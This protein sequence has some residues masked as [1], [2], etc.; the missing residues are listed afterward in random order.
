MKFQIVLLLLLCGACFA[1]ETVLWRLGRKDG[2][3]QDFQI[4]YSP[5]EYGR[6]PYLR[7]NPDKKGF[8]F[9][10]RVRGSEPRP[11]MIDTITHRDNAAFMPEEEIVTT[12][13]LIWE[14]HEPGNRRFLLS[15][16]KERN[17]GERRNGI[18]IVL[19]DRRIQYVDFPASKQQYENF[20]N[21]VF[22][23][24]KGT[25][26]LELEVISHGK[27]A[28]ISFDCMEL[29]KTDAAVD[30]K[31]WLRAD[32]RDPD[33]VFAPG[34]AAELELH[35]FLPSGKA[36]TCTWK[37][38]DFFG[39]TVAKGEEQFRSDQLRL[40]LPSA[41]R[42]WF[43]V[44]CSTPSARVRTAY[45]VLE[46]VRL[47][48]DESSRFGL[49][50]LGD[51]YIDNFDAVAAEKIVRRAWKAGAKHL[52]YHYLKWN[53]R[54][55]DRNQPCSWKNADRRL[56]LMERY[57]LVP[58]IN[59]AGTPKWAS[60]DSSEAL[61]PPIGV[62][63]YTMFAPEEQAWRQF[64]TELVSRWKGRVRY[65]EIWNEPSYVSCFWLDGSPA[66]YGRT[67]KSAYEAAKAVDPECVVLSGGL[68]PAALDFMEEAI[69]SSGGCDFDVMGI[70]YPRESSYEQW[71]RM[72]SRYRGEIPLFNTEE[73][74]WYGGDPVKNAA[75]LVK[76]HVQEAVN[77]VV[78][79]Y[80]FLF[81]RPRHT[82]RTGAFYD[83]FDA[84]E[85]IYAAYR[86]MTHRMD[87]ITFLADLSE[88]TG[89]IFLFER[90]GA[91]VI[92]AWDDKGSEFPAVLAA[93]A[94]IYDLMDNPLP[95][96]SGPVRLTENPLFLAGGDLARLKQYAALRAKLPSTLRV[97][98][99]ESVERLLPSAPECAALPDGWKA[100]YRNGCWRLDI[101]AGAHEGGYLLPL[102]FG[103]GTISL[104]L[105]VE[106]TT[107][108]PGENLIR[109]GNFANGFT[110]W[111]RAKNADLKP[112]KQEGRSALLCRG[113]GRL[114]FGPT[115]KVR[116]QPGENYLVA[117]G[118]K[119]GAGFGIMYSLLDKDNRRIFPAKPGINLLSVKPGTH[120]E[121]YSEEIVI[122][123]PEAAYLKI[124]LLPEVRPDLPMTIDQVALYRLDAVYT[125][126]R[127]LWQGECRRTTPGKIM[128][129]GKAEEW[130]S[131]PG[132]TLDS[133]RR[134]DRPADWKGPRDLSGSA[135]MMIDEKNLYLFF[136]VRD[137][138]FHQ[139]A[140]KRAW[141][142]DSIQFAVDPRLTAEDYH[143]FLLVREGAGKTVLRKL[144][145]YWTP[146]VLTGQIR[147]GIV[148]DAEVVS[149][150]S[151]TGM[152]YEV[153]IP[154]VHL[155]PLTG[156]AHGFGFSFLFNDN[157][158]AGRKYM[159]WSS[160]IGGKKEPA[161]YGIIRVTPQRR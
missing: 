121:L 157:D 80:S 134:V 114:H 48:Y 83:G 55:P 117:V 52:R 95:S 93:G 43:R 58:L 115:G 136:S 51:S 9:E 110:Y 74:R 44:E 50:H 125:A 101:P 45:A 41:R 46:P 22:P 154:L 61:T 161:K 63:R 113:S 112:V 127:V 34:G 90:R 57:R 137:D 39:N 142:G 65:W 59:I 77:G 49:H 68:F 145:N 91:P 105:R 12:L 38:T 76:Q 97:R 131:V 72:L 13:R 54:R 25:N 123:H 126:D 78:R 138:L 151:E 35:R 66:T 6:A 159:E 62:R 18:R 31:P 89:K 28:N 149:L 140:P 102:R 100:Q 148:S 33:H 122:R 21:L 17:I 32:F 119:G 153:R 75:S 124:S 132:M 98:P 29:R 23:V 67:L 152:D 96:D 116:V 99:G 3:Q 7:T 82:K 5:W 81:A 70:H 130:N 26:Q 10:Y 144:H 94:E 103:G 160:G 79:T 146:E 118:L 128:I 139:G 2:K 71:R 120:R 20:L 47:E 64:I 88:G 84:P 69:R 129:D 141:E 107:R 133:G 11:K 24:E 108:E 87:H 143:E 135:R 37:V 15:L 150:R 8:C 40:R 73:S 147:Q 4:N 1:G 106:V 111:F 85:P 56:E 156:K 27:Y 158:G 104:N 36:E 109:N 92:V 60:P 14:E 53:L 19:P 30:L 155:F 42:G 16:A 86:T